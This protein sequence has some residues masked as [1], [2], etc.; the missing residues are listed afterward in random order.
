MGRMRA[1]PEHLKPD[2]QEIVLA[3][4]VPTGAPTVAVLPFSGSHVCLQKHVI[5]GLATQIGE[6]LANIAELVVIAPSS[7]LRYEGAKVDIREAG[8]ELDI[9]F[10]VGG[11]FRIEDQ[12]IVIKTNLADTS[13]GEVLWEDEYRCPLDQLG[14]EIAPRIVVR[15]ATGLVPHLT[16]REIQRAMGVPPGKLTAYDFLLQAMSAMRTLDREEF[17]KARF[18]LAKS[19][20]LDST[21]AMPRA[22]LGRWHSIN[23]GQAWA[24]D[25]QAESRAGLEHA[26]SA[27]RLDPQNSAALATAGH[28]KSY[29]FRDF[30]GALELFER[31]IDCSFSSP[32]AWS[33]SSATLSYLGAATEARR[34]AEHA[35]RLS[36]FDQSIHSYYM[37]A[38]IAAYADYDYANAAKW[39]Q[40]AIG[41]NALHTTPHKLF[42]ACLVG[43]NRLD[44][45]RDAARTL[46]ELEPSFGLGSAKVSPFADSALS[47]V[48]L[49]QLRTAGAIPPAR[50]EADHLTA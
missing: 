41:S 21:Y 50:T 20:S 24:V 28:L 11:S 23:V 17:E 2:F 29:L 7:M 47:R 25:R 6:A 39:A 14:Y 44:E 30:D 43:L 35:I 38:G 15:V 4:P 34:R 5:D 3:R 46:R 22:L 42:T 36:P 9:R 27:I 49:T 19:I 10:I 1:E 37:F 13:S 16:A 33:L 45:A 26:L 8:R 18:L 40:K 31:A 12:L 48:Y 32:L